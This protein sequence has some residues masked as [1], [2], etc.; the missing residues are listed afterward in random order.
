MLLINFFELFIQKNIRAFQRGIISQFWSMGCKTVGPQSLP[1]LGI[2]PGLPEDHNFFIVTRGSLLFLG[3]T[4]FHTGMGHYGPCYLRYVRHVYSFE[5]R[6][7]KLHD[8]V[9][10]GIYQG[11]VKP[12]L[13]FFHKI[14]KNYIS[15]IIQGP[16]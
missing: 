5:V 4:L 3:L 6:L 12:L 8:F 2:E 14:L 16:R 10:F 15:K 7:I 13:T 9:H 11:L 1:R